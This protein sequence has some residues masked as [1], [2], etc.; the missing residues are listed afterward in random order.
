MENS[1]GRP[2]FM[3]PAW[4][5]WCALTFIAALPN[6]ARAQLTP[7]LTIQESQAVMGWI[8]HRVASARQ[9]FCYRQSDPRGVGTPLSTCGEGTQKDGALCYPQCKANYTGVGPVCWEQCPAGHTDTG[10]FCTRGA[11]TDH[12]HYQSADCPHG[13]KNMGASCYRVWPPKS[14]SMSHMTCPAGMSRKG[15]FCYASCPSGFTNTGTTCYR[16][17]S[18]ITKSSYGRTAGKPMQCE[19]G[20]QEDAGLC[21][22]QCRSNF[23]GVGPVCWQNCQAGKAECGVGCAASA[24]QCRSSTADMVIAPVML[25]VNILT[26]GESEEITA[27]KAEMKAAAK[28]KD[29]RAAASAFTRVLDASVTRLEEMTTQEITQTLKKQFTENAF[30]W[31]AKEWIKLQYQVM[32]KQ[33]DPELDKI[34]GDVAALDPTGV[35]SVVQAYANP[36]CS[37][38]EPFPAVRPTY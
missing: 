7:P 15:G 31:V 19:A 11:Q 32:L 13:F 3:R 1:I 37:L 14:I 20:K 22:S 23:H 6:S 38:D 33:Q 24:S 21:Y 27:A 9:A 4:L 28:A 5:I 36:K 12:L 30:K 25:A 8:S 16:G 10:A 18:T 26:F 2:R 34:L 35:A 29:A 17:P